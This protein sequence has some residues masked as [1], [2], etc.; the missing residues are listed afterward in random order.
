MEEI[1][2][3]KNSKRFKETKIFIIF[4]LL[5]AILA[6]C[7]PV[8]NPS[9]AS[10]NCQFELSPEFNSYDFGSE[11]TKYIFVL[12][13]QSFEYKY[14]PEDLELLSENITANMFA[15]DRLVVAW[16]NLDDSTKTIIFDERIEK[17]R[18]PQFPPTFSAPLLTP[19]LT[20]SHVT[21]IQ[22]QQIQTNEAI[23]KDNKVI[24]EKHFCK[25]GEWNA[26]S[27][28]KFNHWRHEQDEEI[29]SFKHEA[30]EVLQPSIA[31]ETSSGRL[32]YES[33]STASQMLQSAIS[34]QQ[35]NKYILIVFSNMDD[36]RPEK[37]EEVQINLTGIDTLI[38]SQ[39]CKYEI[40]CTVKS[41]WEEQLIDFG[42][43]SPLFL[44][45]EDNI[46]EFLHNYLSSIP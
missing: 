1:N 12:I 38:V 45:K 28:E 35:H 4:S 33:F 23:D 3:M 17:V 24:N 8:F 32:I 16:I 22:G 37:P 30:N 14:T 42:A 36:W 31:K 26:Q 6:G 13:D 11:E 19:H 39:H 41:V 10:G 46:P 43:V 2:T 15:G 20:P 5:F 29:S 25:I 40:D 21:T 44:V 27:D 7:K 18:K 9:Q 34:K